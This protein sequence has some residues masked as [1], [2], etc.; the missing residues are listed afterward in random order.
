M[1]MSQDVRPP[2]ADVIDEPVAV[3]VEQKR[4]FAAFEKQWL[5]P[6]SAKRPRRAVDAA[7]DK[8]LG[9]VKGSMTL[10]AVNGH[11]GIGVFE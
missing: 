5:A 11:G 10:V 6:D 7:G 8:L 4:P 3:D 9:A 1:A 2:R